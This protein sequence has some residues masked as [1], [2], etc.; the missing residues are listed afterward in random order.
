MPVYRLEYAGSGNWIELADVW[1][2]K[3]MRDFYQAALSGDD[4]R[5]FALLRAKLTAVHIYTVDG[6][7]VESADALIECMDDLDVRI[8]RWLATGIMQMLQ[9]NMSLGEAKRRLLYDGIEVAAKKPTTT[10]A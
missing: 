10:T 5:T 3:E 1:T 9:E 8:V 6:G 2:R 4:E 7:I